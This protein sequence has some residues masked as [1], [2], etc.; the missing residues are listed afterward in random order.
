M[1]KVEVRFPK[2][3]VNHPLGRHLENARSILRGSRAPSMVDENEFLSGYT[4]RRGSE[5]PDLAAVVGVSGI[6]GHS[7]AT[8]VYMP[9]PGEKPNASFRTLGV[10]DKPD[11]S[12]AMFNAPRGVRHEAI[13]AYPT[14]NRQK[15]QEAYPEL[16]ENV[17]EGYMPV[18]RTGE[19]SYDEMPANT[20][21]E[22]LNRFR[23]ES[24]NTGGGSR[25]E[26]LPVMPARRTGNETLPVMPTRGTPRGGANP[27]AHESQ[28]YQD[29][30][31]RLG[32][33]K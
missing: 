7:G 12:P 9:V 13:P 21:P 18:W 32:V 3:E 29:M 31:R 24:L 10:F 4:D 2:K 11:G 22:V 20:P 16:L 19:V 25:N 1:A 14:F 26:A 6:G 15:T 27:F 5:G 8:R 28:E 33:I 30:M 17:R 23:R